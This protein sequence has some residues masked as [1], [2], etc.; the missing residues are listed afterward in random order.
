[1]ELLY[2]ELLQEA[3]LIK[4]DLILF[5]ALAPWGKLI[6]DDLK[7]LSVSI[8]SFMAINEWRSLSFWVYTINFFIDCL[9]DNKEI[10]I[11]RRYKTTLQQKFHFQRNKL[12]M[13]SFL[14]N[15]GD[16]NVITFHRALQV[17]GD[18]FTADYL[19]LGPSAVYRQSEVQLT[20]IYPSQNLIY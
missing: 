11:I 17:G 18:N 8:I 4:P 5:D 7:C 13:L 2:A 20:N 15:K 9:Q 14:M 1:T 6:S 19:F 3:K 10:R 12:N 16:I